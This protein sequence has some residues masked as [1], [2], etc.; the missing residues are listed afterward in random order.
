[1][2]DDAFGL[3]G[4]GCALEQDGDRL[5]VVPWDGLHKRL[6]VLPLGI[7]ITIDKGEL[8][9]LDVIRSSGC[10][11]LELQDSTGLVSEASL[12]LHMKDRRSSTRATSGGSA[13]PIQEEDG[14]FRILAPWIDAAVRIEIVFE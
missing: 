8:R 11:T 7:D 3:V 5:S 4:F 12:I 1:M 6:A 13:I 14:G 9:R 2:E 10:V